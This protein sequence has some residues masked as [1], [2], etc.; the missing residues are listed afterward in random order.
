[1]AD[2]NKSFYQYF[3]ENMNALGGLP[4]PEDFFGTKETAIATIAGIAKYIEKYGTR[5]T[6][7]ELWEIGPKWTAVMAGGATAVSVSKAVLEGIVV[8]GGLSAAAY[9]GACIGS[10]AVATGEVL[11]NHLGQSPNGSYSWE[12]AD[13]VCSLYGIPF[14]PC[15]LDSENRPFPGKYV[16]WKKRYNSGMC[17]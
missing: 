7:H 9:L 17:R 4:A 12:A 1:M 8:L 15:L 16:D 10:L 13:R 2:G 11:A 5:V 3:K 6:V 14:S